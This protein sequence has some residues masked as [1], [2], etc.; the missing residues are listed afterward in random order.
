M[1]DQ[2]RPDI[3]DWRLGIEPGEH[4]P[5][6]PTS[7]P[8]G[9]PLANRSID[10]LNTPL[11][12][13]TA[14][15]L[16]WA[17]VAIYALITRLGALGVRPL[18]P[19][20]AG[21]ALFAR[22]IA[23]SGLAVFA[24]SVQF[25][26]GWLAPLR[27][28]VFTVVGTSDFS[29]R[30]ITAL[31]GLALIAA[32]FSMRRNLGRAGALA[33]ATMLTTSPT[34]TY[35]SRAAAAEIPAITLIV[36]ALALMFALVGKNDTAKVV[37]LAVTIALALAASAIVLP[38]AAIFLAILL[39]LG[40]RE[41]FRRNPMLR[42]RVWWERRFAALIFAVVIVMALFVLFESG[43][44]RRNFLIPVILGM[45]DWLPL[46]Q[47]TSM[48]EAFRAGLT[49][50]SPPLVFY[51]FFVL[52]FAAIGVV[53]FLALQIRS[54]LVAI[55]FL[56][57][58]LA[59]AFFLIDPVRHPEWLVMMLVPA[60]ILAAAAIDWLHHFDGW[61]F[62]RYPIAVVA[63]LSVYIQFA[64][65]FVHYAPDYTEASWS[66]HLLLFWTDPATT[67][68]AAE[69]F[70]HAER[71]VTDNGSVFL[72]DPDPVARWYLR[73]LK[74]ADTGSNA[75]I[76]IAPP[77]A[78]PEPNQIQ[79]YEFPLE[80]SW[81]PDPAIYSL[82]AALRYFFTQRAQSEVF[83]HEIRI[84]VRSHTPATIPPLESANPTPSATPTVVSPVPA[85][86][87]PAP[88]NDVSSATATPTESP[89]ATATLEASPTAT[90]TPSSAPAG[91]A[92]Y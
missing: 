35:F 4:R 91:T 2:L 54:R 69:E 23:R 78:A 64:I 41:S 12:V 68:Q 26:S 46:L 33:L 49:F 15:H 48:S 81:Q 31:F 22:D 83:S 19:A 74:D 57:T 80:E 86:A 58:I 38:I 34:L 56:W 61:R 1:P 77:A 73:G 5:T 45:Q 29:A 36:V 25:G 63:L 79:S 43:F 59:G 52:I 88:T 53:A 84:E 89:S 70:S 87:A 28:G 32:A 44:G 13:V 14:E 37:A 71:A 11:Y 76:V 47:Q 82:S 20:E 75:D 90:A 85:E 24:S 67:I 7:Q 72:A 92:T 18:T 62:I 8:P 42:F 50:Y 10:R 16:G 39:L 9:L 3:D 30:L 6:T 17:A 65:N 66:R 55:A 40:I 21:D 27:A 60:T 51:E